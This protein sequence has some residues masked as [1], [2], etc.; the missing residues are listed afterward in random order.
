LPTRE[1][2]SFNEASDEAAIS[3][4]YGGIHYMPAIENGITQGRALGR[5]VVGQLRTRK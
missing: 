1:F 2:N 3:R 4:L 5:Y